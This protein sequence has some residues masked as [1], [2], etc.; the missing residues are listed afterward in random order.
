M[1]A[2]DSYQAHFAHKRKMEAMQRM[3]DWQA[4]TWSQRRDMAMGELRRA[5]RYRGYPES[6]RPR[7]RC[8]HYR[9]SGKPFYAI[10]LTNQGRER[11]RNVY[12]QAERWDTLIQKLAFRQWSQ[13][14]G[15][16]LERNWR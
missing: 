6:A 1:S 9:S 8:F 11:R 5:M 3:R 16:R 13:L 14:S 4:R 7:I 2:D 10:V 15:S 12:L